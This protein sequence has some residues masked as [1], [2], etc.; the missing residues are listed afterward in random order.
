MLVY[1]RVFSGKKTP[2]QLRGNSSRL[3]WRSCRPFSV[4]RSAE[5]S[6]RRFST[7]CRRRSFSSWA[8][9]DTWGPGAAR[10]GQ[11]G[12]ST[13]STME[14]KNHGKWDLSMEMGAELGFFFDW[15]WEHQKLGSSQ[16]CGFCRTIWANKLEAWAWKTSDKWELTMENAEVAKKIPVINGLMYFFC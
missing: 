6:R 10:N 9:T 13:E 12:E 2:P 15:K 7:I 11:F 1:Q 14:K 8:K 5:T 16:L 4:N 3:L